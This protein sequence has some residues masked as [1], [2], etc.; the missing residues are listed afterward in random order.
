MF[1]LGYN[2]GGTGTYALT[3]NGRLSSYYPE[4][5]GYSGT[6]TFTQTGGTNSTY[7]GDLYL[8]YNTGSSGLYALSGTGQLSAQYEAVGQSGTG[9]FTQTGGTNSIAG[10]SQPGR[11]RRQR[12]LLQ[13]R[14][15]RPVDGRLRNDRLRSRRHW[16]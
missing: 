10:G 16:R 4:Y 9:I 3:G 12:R 5:V 7:Y 11:H 1:Y 13:P 2:S 8:G 14:R 15:D 6:G